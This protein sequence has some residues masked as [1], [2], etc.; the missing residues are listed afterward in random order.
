MNKNLK[1]G[2]SVER[3]V[4]IRNHFC[5]LKTML[6]EKLKKLDDGDDSMQNPNDENEGRFAI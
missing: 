3:L 6:L 1:Q 2:V 4:Q 5:D